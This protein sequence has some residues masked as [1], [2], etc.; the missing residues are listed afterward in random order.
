MAQGDTTGPQ[1]V[2][3]KATSF[4]VG[5]VVR[6]GDW[7]GIR[8]SI[9]D[10]ADKARE[11]VVRLTIRDADG[12]RA[13]YESNLTSS[14]GQALSHWTY[15]KIPPRFR[16]GDSI[17][18]QVFAG[19]EQ[20]APSGQRPTFAAGRLLGSASL[21]SAIVVDRTRGLIGVAG[22]TQMG[23]QRYSGPDNG[24][25]N[26]SD[27]Q[28]LPGSHEVSNLVSRLD[29]EAI[30]DRWIG[31]ALFDTIVWNDP[32]LSRLGT[33]G[34]A[35]IREWVQRGGHLIVV[36]PRI[37]QTWTDEKNNPL[38]D[39]CPRVSA[40]RREGVDLEPYRLLITRDPKLAMPAREIVHVLT[41]LPDAAPDEAMPILS[42]PDREG[43]V[44]RRIFGVGDVTFV[45]LDVASE[46]M[47]N[48]S[49]PEPEMF[50]HRVLGRRGELYQPKSGET[51]F[52]HADRDIITLDRDIA[53]QIAKT[54]R[55]ELGVFAGLVVFVVYW[56]VAGPLGYTALKRAGRVHH[57][58]VAFVL[59]GGLFTAIA[60]GGAMAI[61]P[62]R[63]Q[64]SHLTLLDHVYG[65]ATQRARSWISLLVPS[66][67]DA[68]LT[69][70]DP[71]APSGS[72][73][74]NAIAPWEPDGA[75]TASFPDARGYRIDSRSPDRITFPTR[76]TVKQFQLDWAGGPA[77]KMLR[78]IS[79]DGDPSKAR[80]WLESEPGERS[81]MPKNVRLPVRGLLT[82]DLPGPLS[83]VVII[84]NRGQRHVTA[85]LGAGGPLLSDIGAYRLQDPWKPGETLDLES[86][87]ATLDGDPLPFLE[88]LIG[89]YVG[90]PEGLTAPDS[91]PARVTARQVALALMPQLQ[92]PARPGTSNSRDRLAQ[93]KA[94]HGWDLGGW[95]T[96]PCI[97]I[98]GQVGQR[99]SGPATP[100]PLYMSTGGSA[101]SVS[102]SGRTVVRWVYPLPPD[103]PR[104]PPRSA[105]PPTSP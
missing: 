4:G 71:A 23:L 69:T 88:Q 30:P 93:R 77:W 84:V 8:L 62:Q 31:L 37:G 39:I 46:W 53:D 49:M 17:Q 99:E 105:E 73:Q 51:T 87:V 16:Q 96:Q 47:R 2:E 75:P 21:T 25:T 7:A 45:G 83:D 22:A 32:T 66:Y 29:A 19:S 79:P 13:Q 90:S 89:S 95:F 6:P 78:P 56:L 36:L 55:A 100:I 103:P 35:A 44:V 11:L 63:V 34:S 85:S 27:L 92:P 86:K 3:I 80:L 61:R 81:S 24:S 102:S 82:H 41:P 43:L 18:A 50:W 72:R 1:D 64:A 74:S 58:W 38:F 26:Q 94:T 59:A 15:V 91:D 60:W 12:D 97:M 57:A 67:G 5:G 98:I 42:G 33:A 20:A 68:T 40:A 48:H 76:A 70:S 104:V 54:G 101:R 65:Q 28:G 10:S 14:P 52:A 9:R